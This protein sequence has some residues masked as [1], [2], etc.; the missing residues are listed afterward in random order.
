MNTGPD[1]TDCTDATEHQDVEQLDDGH[2]YVCH[3]C[4]TDTNPQ[5]ISVLA[6]ARDLSMDHVDRDY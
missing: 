3:R 2:R 6:L 1:P 4:G 5:G